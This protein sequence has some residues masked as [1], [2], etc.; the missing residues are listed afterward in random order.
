MKKTIL[1]LTV[2][3]L[4]SGV[5]AAATI[6]PVYNTLEDAQ[7][8][9]EHLKR[10]GVEVSNFGGKVI[11]LKDKDN[12]QAHITKTETGYNIVSSQGETKVTVNDQGQITHVDG[13]DASTGK[14]VIDDENKVIVDKQTE[15]QVDANRQEIENIKK[16]A[17]K[18]AG[19]AYGKADNWARQAYADF[20]QEVNR[21][22]AKID[23]VE[24]RVSNGAAMAG[25]MT[26]MQFGHDGF[27]VGAGVANFNGSNAIAV[28]VGYAFGNEKQ[29]MAKGSF[30]Y[31]KSNKGNKSTDTMAAAGLTYSFK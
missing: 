16:D 15:A 1:A 9:L 19:I 27:G 26:Q 14:V 2:T 6:K 7:R 20:Q 13:K 21:L 11:H 18:E 28:G 29:W 4:F 23:S 5:A 22:D 30:G 24:G 31:A 10:N 12:N 25:A 17:E 3:S 8:T